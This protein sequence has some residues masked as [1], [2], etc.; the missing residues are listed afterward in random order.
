MVIK[1]AFVISALFHRVALVLTAL[2]L[3]YSAITIQTL[4]FGSR[5]KQGVFPLT[6]LFC[7][8]FLVEALCRSG[9][10]F[11]EG[12]TTHDVFE[13]FKPFAEKKDLDLKNL[14]AFAW[15]S[16]GTEDSGLRFV[17]R[18]ASLAFAVYLVVNRL[19]LGRGASAGSRTG[20]YLVQTILCVSAFAALC[21]MATMSCGSYFEQ[22]KVDLTKPPLQQAVSVAGNFHICLKGPYGIGDAL[23]T[24]ALLH[25]SL[26]WTLNS[27]VGLQHV[28][29]FRW[30]SI[31][32]HLLELY[33][34]GDLINTIMRPKFDA[35]KLETYAVLIQ[36]IL[37]FFLFIPKFASR[38]PISFFILLIIISGCSAIAFGQVHVPLDV[39][40]H[41]QPIVGQLFVL[42]S[43]M[44]VVFTGGVGI[45]FAMFAVAGAA[46]V[47]APWLKLLPEAQ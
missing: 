43:L 21:G 1:D 30:A 12:N 9:I 4:R 14:A 29:A 37:V 11:A 20:G 42:F 15:K 45:S 7:L 25:A 27:W 31:A 3:V 18:I 6:F 47:N 38:Q 26:S 35:T 33:L 24:I 13:A 17:L 2:S 5:N 23:A 32:V 19:A 40:Y 34:K 44:A 36:V 41:V 10:I 8:M 22:H 16:L 46:Q 28:L 39:S